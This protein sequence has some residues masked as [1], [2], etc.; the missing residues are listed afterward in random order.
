MGVGVEETKRNQRSK[1]WVGG[2]AEEDVLWG[3]GRWAGITEGLCGS[4]I[5]L[6]VWWS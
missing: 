1:M 2:W 5:W 3:R 6:I 4:N